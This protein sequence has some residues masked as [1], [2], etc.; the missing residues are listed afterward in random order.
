MLLF[1]NIEHGEGYRVVSSDEA[2]D[3]Q[4]KLIEDDREMAAI[5]MGA[6]IR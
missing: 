4:C 6:D 1:Q 5:I 2:K 3:N